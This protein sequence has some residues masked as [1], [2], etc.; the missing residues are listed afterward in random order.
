MSRALGE[1]AVAGVRTTIPF[2]QWLLAEPD[3]VTGRVDTT[4]LDCV[5]ASRNGTPFVVP[6]ADTQATAAIAAA[7]DAY[8]RTHTNGASGGAP[9]ASAWTRSARRDALR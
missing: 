4:T 1:F 8:F 3:F 9:G 6:D 2:F 5:L 7:F